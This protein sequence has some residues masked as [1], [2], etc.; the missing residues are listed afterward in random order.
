MEMDLIVDK[1]LPP[2]PPPPMRS[3]GKVVSVEGQLALEN[4]E[5]KNTQKLTWLAKCGPAQTTP[6]M[7]YHFDHIITKGVLK[8][9]DDFKDFINYNSKVT[10]ATQ[11]VV[12]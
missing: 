11:Y 7:C 5:F 6:T 10:M 2:P 9:E 4:T 12:G 8:P 1:L 3:E